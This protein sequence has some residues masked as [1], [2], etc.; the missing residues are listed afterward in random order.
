MKHT[1]LAALLASSALLTTAGIATAEPADSGGAPATT[2]HDAR[3]NAVNLSVLGMLGGGFNL[4][5]ERMVG[6]GDGVV[7]EVGSTSWRG[8]SSESIDGRIVRESEIDARHAT[9][10][11]GYRRHW[12]G[13]QHGGFAGVML[14]QNVGSAD[15]RVTD[16]RDEAA[17]QVAYRS[18]TLTAHVG[19][20]WMLTDAINLTIRVGAGIADRDVIDTGAD[21]MAVARLADAIDLPL[22]VD[23]E[24]SLGYTF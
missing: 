22:A 23:G 5:Y 2:R 10:G 15:V 18:T 4:T 13:G 3:R 11:I 20:R 7:L 16:G 9:L 21:P 1:C 24:L 12:R 17:D 19:K 6:D 14:H 8:G